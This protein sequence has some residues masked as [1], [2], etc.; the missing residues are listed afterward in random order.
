MKYFPSEKKLEDLQIL[1]IELEE[2]IGKDTPHFKKTMNYS[3]KNPLVQKDFQELKLEG[4][5]YIS[6]NY[7]GVP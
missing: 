4:I 5:V 6:F 7:F 2:F 3:Q 1:M